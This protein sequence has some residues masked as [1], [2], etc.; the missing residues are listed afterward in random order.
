M[1]V[2]ISC[3]SPEVYG[4]N[5]LKIKRKQLDNLAELAEANPDANYLIIKRARLKSLPAELALFKQLDSLDLYGN[6]IEHIPD[7][8]WIILK[9]VKYLRL[10]K[11]P[12][13]ELPEAIT[14]LEKLESL[15]LWNSE[16]SY[17]HPLF[18][19]MS[20]QIKKLDIR[21]TR[22]SRGQTQQIHDAFP[23]TEVKATWQCNC[24]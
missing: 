14:Q 12:M 21:M 11:N 1:L 7:S 6:K 10:G 13:E 3:F 20:D 5:T 17:I 19:T 22:L 4:Q 8:A 23:H 24:K 16:I 18:L 9:N 2:L 15:D